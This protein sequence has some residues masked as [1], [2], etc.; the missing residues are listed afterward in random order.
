MSNSIQTIF[1]PIA[2][3]ATNTSYTSNIRLRKPAK[4]VIVKDAVFHANAASG[5]IFTIKSDLIHGGDTLAYF[6]D[7]GGVMGVPI[8]YTHLVNDFSDSDVTFTIFDYTGKTGT[9]P[10]LGN[11]LLVLEFHS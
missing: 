4:R 5:T 3:D 10:G 11:L 8:N 1:V 6:K 9:P 7:T 2:T